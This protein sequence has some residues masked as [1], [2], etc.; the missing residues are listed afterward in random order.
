MGQEFESFTPKPIDQCL[1]CMMAPMLGLGGLRL[2][3]GL[4]RLIIYDGG[5]SPVTGDLSVRLRGVG[6]V[7]APHC[8]SRA[9]QFDT[10]ACEV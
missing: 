4:L 10:Q 6:R 2:Y 5:C 3:P 1:C 7:E 8:S 9:G